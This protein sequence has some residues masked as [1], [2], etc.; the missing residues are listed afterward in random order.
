MIEMSKIRK[1]K[2]EKKKLKSKVKSKKETS[3]IKYIYIKGENEGC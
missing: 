3:Q 1:V 2:V